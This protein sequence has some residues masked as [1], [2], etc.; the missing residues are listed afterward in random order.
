MTSL[1]LP[2]DDGGTRE[3]RLQAATT[4]AKPAAPLTARRAS[5]AAHVIPEV[6]GVNTT[7]A[8]AQLDWEAPRA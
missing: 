2:T 3:Y 5:A 4:W 6:A 8:P 1:I 7:G